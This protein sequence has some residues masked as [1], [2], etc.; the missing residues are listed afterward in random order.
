MRRALI[1]AFLLLLGSTVLGATVCREDIAHATG[2]AP[3]PSNVV[4]TNTST[5]PVPVTEQNTDSDVGGSIKVHEE[6]TAN[7]SVTQTPIILGAG[8]GFKAAT[9][10]GG[11]VSFA[12]VTASALSIHM[13][14]GV[15]ALALDYQGNVVA[16]FA[17]PGNTTPGN[18]SIDLALT[19]PVK[20]D[21]IECSGGGISETASV[22]FVGA[23][24]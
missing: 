8:G 16:A 7:V 22:S 17:G 2:L 6:G 10:A 12:A 24:P 4:V 18:A 1:P 3:S 20:F 19:R 23:L 9:C 15:T 13:T 14:S 5:N 21:Q 11:S